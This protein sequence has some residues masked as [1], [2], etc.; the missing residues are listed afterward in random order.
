[1][2]QAGI[3]FP[4]KNTHKKAHKNILNYRGPRSTG[5]IGGF[6][7]DIRRIPPPP[8]TSHARENPVEYEHN[9]CGI[10]LKSLLMP[11]NPPGAMSK[12]GV[13]VN[14]HE[15]GGGADACECRRGGSVHMNVQEGLVIF[16]WV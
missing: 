2:R 7:G 5:C 3:F 9:P 16:P 6:R 1:M 11:P 13:V 4:L 15:Q 14:V 8:R 10:R 12:G